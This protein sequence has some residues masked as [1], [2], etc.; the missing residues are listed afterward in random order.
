MILMKK[1]ISENYLIQAVKELKD[2]LLLLMI[3]QQVIIKFLLIRTK[4]NFFQE[5]K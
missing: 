5:L 2:Y 1:N 4:N 3:I